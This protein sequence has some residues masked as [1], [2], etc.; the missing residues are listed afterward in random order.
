MSFP[1]SMRMSMNVNMNGMV[2]KVA[3]ISLAQRLNHQLEVLPSPFRKDERKVP[4]G[5]LM[6]QFAHSHAI[7]ADR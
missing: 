7:L 2:P 4:F 5:G 3:Q 6:V 1:N